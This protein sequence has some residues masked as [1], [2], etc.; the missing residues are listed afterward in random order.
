MHKLH[1]ELFVQLQSSTSKIPVCM[2]KF[3]L[4][5]LLTTSFI[6]NNICTCTRMEKNVLVYVHN[7]HVCI[8]TQC[9]L[10]VVKCSFCYALTLLHV[11]LGSPLAQALLITTQPFTSVKQCETQKLTPVGI[12]LWILCSRYC[13]CSIEGCLLNK[14]WNAI[15]NSHSR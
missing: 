11:C 3:S 7:V 13:V 14:E 6:T 10:N 5:V 2:W 9:T 15:H 4:S 12:L 1:V 8:V